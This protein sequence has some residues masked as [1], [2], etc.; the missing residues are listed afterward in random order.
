MM[1]REFFCDRCKQTMV[2]EQPIEEVEAEEKAN[3]GKIPDCDR[4]SLCDECH[5]WFMGKMAELTDKPAP[6]PTDPIE[7]EALF[8]AKEQSKCE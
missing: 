1:T 3:W 6:W 2:T 5:Q 8:A 4:V 7:V